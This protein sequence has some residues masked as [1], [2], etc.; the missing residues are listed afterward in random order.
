ML[1]T[2]NSLWFSNALLALGIM[3]GSSWVG[4]ATARLPIQTLN[5]KLHERLLNDDRT[6]RS[7]AK[8]LHN[9]Q[10]EPQTP[11]LRIALGRR[12]LEQGQLNS[13]KLAAEAAIELAPTN[14]EGWQLLG[15][16]DANSQRFG[17]ALTNYQHALGLAPNRPDLQ[18]RIAQSYLYL[19]RTLRAAS[20]L[21][22]L[23]NN[24]EQPASLEAL[25][26]YGNVMQ[27]IGQHSQ[28]AHAFTTA[29]QQPNATC[30]TFIR[31]SHSQILA[32]DVTA[33]A[34]TLQTCLQKF[35]QSNE[36]RELLNQIANQQDSDLAIR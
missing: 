33:S 21:E 16:V 29:S 27:E 34:A 6:D 4:C 28:A 18:L 11:E 5:Q 12:F 10:R 9:I 20:T 23:V 32:G 8:L 31:L 26:L 30:D 7:I 24:P 14:A 2:Q 17:E 25:T 35:P 15:D 3:F 19:G 1:A 13:A 22:N 36:A